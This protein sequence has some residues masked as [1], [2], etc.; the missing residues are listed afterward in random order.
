MANC[1]S[2]GVWDC[3]CGIG[4]GVVEFPNT[5]FCS[6]YCNRRLH[7]GEEFVGTSLSERGGKGSQWSDVDGDKSEGI[8][9]LSAKSTLA[10]LEEFR[11]ESGVSN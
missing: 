1:T 2:I 8:F 5:V 6:T 7:L 4:A 9:C 11:I 3:S 10:G